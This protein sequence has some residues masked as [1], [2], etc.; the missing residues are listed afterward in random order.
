[1]ISPPSLAA[2]RSQT[3]PTIL[4][5]TTATEPGTQS[6]VDTPHLAS[7]HPST[8][9]PSS[10]ASSTSSTSSSYTHTISPVLVKSFSTPNPTDEQ[11]TRMRFEYMAFQRLPVELGRP[12]ALVSHEEEGLCLLYEDVRGEAID[13]VL[14]ENGR[15]AT[16]QPITDHTTAVEHIRSTSIHNTD[17]AT[18]VTLSPHSP[19]LPTVPSHHPKTLR[20]LSS[21]LRIARSLSNFLLR[22]HDNHVIYKCLRPSTILFNADTDRCLLLEYQSSSLLSRE[23]A[24]IEE[25]SEDGDPGLLSYISPEQ[26]GRMNRV[27]D[28]RTDIYSL[29][30]VMYEMLIGQPPFVSS[31]PL[32]IIHFH[33]AKACPDPVVLL[34][35]RR[36]AAGDDDKLSDRERKALHWLG[37]IILKCVAKQA[38]DRYQSA[39]G[40]LS[41]LDF[42]YKLL[43]SA[44]AEAAGLSVPATISPLVIS[45]SLTPD[46]R[47]S[48]SASSLSAVSVTSPLSQH[49]GVSPTSSPTMSSTASNQFHVGRTDVLS[50]FRISQRLYGREEQVKVLL[51]AFDRVS[52]DIEPATPSPSDSPP[53]PVRPELVLIAG[54]SGIGKT[55]VVDE[56]QRPI[57]K[58][59][60]LIARGKFD[61]YRRN[62]S[63]LLAAFQQLIMQLLTQDTTVWKHK[64]LTALGTDAQL[65][66]DVMPELERLIGPQSAVP[67]LPA[68]DTEKRFIRTFMNFVAVFCA[69]DHPLTLFI[70]D[71]QWSDT[72]SLHLIRSLFMMDGAF[73][74]IIGAYRDNE[75]PP[76]HPLIRMVEELRE[77]EMGDRI[78]CIML[79]PLQLHHITA[80]VS[81]TLRCST[82][83]AIELARLL[84]MRTQG[85]PF[86]ISSILQSL[87]TSKLIAF[88]YK[89]GRWTWDM[90][91]LRFAN[92]SSDVVDLLCGQIQRLEPR[93]QELMKL[94]ACIGN[95]FSLW[96]LA[97]V[98]EAAEEEVTYEM[99]QVS[100][101]G[102]IIPLHSQYEL[103]VLAENY[104]LSKEKGDT[105]PA[106]PSVS[107]SAS[108]TS[109][110]AP[111]HSTPAPVLSSSISST[112]PTP[113]ASSISPASPSQTTTALIPS[114]NSRTVLFRFAHDRIQQAASQLIP[115]NERQ[116][117]HL[118]IGRLLLSHCTVDTLDNSVVDIVNHFNQ[119][120]TIQ[121]LTSQ[122][123]MR[124]VI[125]L[126]LRAAHKARQS[127]AYA[128]AVEYLQAALQ[129]LNRLL[130]IGADGAVLEGDQRG[131][132]ECEYALSV[133]IHV[134]L[135]EALRLNVQLDEADALAV[136]AFAHTHTV[137]DQVAL[138]EVR[139][140]VS[141]LRGST[142]D[143]C[144]WGVKSLKLLGYELA[145]IEEVRDL[146]QHSEQVFAEFD[147]I[148]N[149]KEMTNPHH[150]AIFRVLQTTT[151]CS[152]LVSSSAYYLFSSVAYG[153]VRFSAEHGITSM[154]AFALSTFSH[155]L[156]A[157]QQPH[158][159]YK[160]GQMAMHMLDRQHAPNSV[161]AKVQT[162]Y[163]GCCVF[164]MEPLSVAWQGCEDTAEL[165]EQ[166]GDFEF[167]GF[168]RTYGQA[169][170]FADGQPLEKVRQ[171]QLNMMSMF[172]RKK[173]HGASTYLLMYRFLLA[174]LI[175]EIPAD[176]DTMLY[177]DRLVNLEL[178]LEEL[179]EARLTMFQLA[180]LSCQTMLNY[181]MRRF[182]RAVQAGDEGW[183]V[184]LH[185]GHSGAA[186]LISNVRL[187]VYYALS[188]L[189]ATP[190]VDLEAIR[191]PV[192]LNIPDTFD[193][194][195][196]FT[197]TQLKRA[198][199]L[200]AAAAAQPSPRQHDRVSP[201]SPNRSMVAKSGVY[202]NLTVQV[203][204]SN[205]SLSTS[206]VLARV[207]AI[208]RYVTLWAQHNPTNFLNKQLL[209][210]AERLRV[211]IFST[212]HVQ[213]YGPRY[214]LIPHALRLYE[215]SIALS[216]E[217]GFTQEEALANELCGRF[218]LAAN[219][220]RE[221]EGFLRSAYWCWAQYGCALK[222]QQMK[223]EFPH[224]FHT[225]SPASV[226]GSSGAP[227]APTG[228][229]TVRAVAGRSAGEMA[230][231]SML[232][233]D[234]MNES[235]PGAA[236]SMNMSHDSATAALSAT[237]TASLNA[238][239][240]FS[241]SLPMAAS[242]TSAGSGTSPP[243]SRP[244]GSHPP[245]TLATAANTAFAPAQP[246]PSSVSAASPSSWDH[247]DIAAVMKACMAFS[248]ET[249]LSKLTRSLLWLVIQ[250]AGASRGTLL[251]KTG[252]QW[253]VELVVSVE[254]KEGSQSVAGA[255]G[256]MKAIGSS[257]PLSM[258]N[259]VQSTHTAVLLSGNEVKQGA[260]QKDAYLSTHRPKACLAVPI[261]QQNKLTGLLYLQNDHTADSFTRTHL[262][263]LTVLTQQAALSIENARLYARLQQRT[264]ELQSNNSQLQ[265]EVVQRQAAQDAMRVAKEAAEKAAETKSAFL[266]NMSHEIRTPMNAVLGASRLLLDTDLTAEQ[267]SYLTM[268]TN[269]GKLLLTIINDV[270]DFSRIESN[271]LELEYRR[272]SLMECVEN[273]CHLCFD[274]AHKKQLD[275]AYTVDRHVPGY[276]Y[277]D[278]SRLQQILLNLLSNAC[279][280]TPPGGQI[281]VTVTCRL[282]DQGAPAVSTLAK[283][284]AAQ[285]LAQGHSPASTASSVAFSTPADSNRGNGGGISNSAVRSRIISATPQPQPSRRL[286]GTAQPSINTSSSASSTVGITGTP[287]LSQ[288]AHNSP[289]HT[290]NAPSTPHT[291]FTPPTRQY[292]ELEF[293]VRDTGLG[294][295]EETQSR[296]FKSFSQGDSSV[297]RRFGGTG[298]GLAISKRL[299][300]AM[301]GSMGCTSQVGEGS[302]FTFTIQTACASPASSRRTLISSAAAEPLQ[303]DP[304]PFMLSPLAS[305]VLP[306]VALAAPVVTLAPL[307]KLS[308][309]ELM[310]L[311]GKRIMLVSD[312]RASRETVV[313]L[314]SSYD[315]QVHAVPSL[316]A[317]MDFAQSV[318]SPKSLATHLSGDAPAV[319]FMPNGVILDYKG[320]ST[321]PQQMDIIDQ[322]MRAFVNTAYAVARA[323][324][325]YTQQYVAPTK[326]P[327]PSLYTDSPDDDAG[328]DAPASFTFTP[329]EPSTA[330]TS[331]PSNTS[332]PHSALSTISRLSITPAQRVLP[333]MAH[334]VV[335]MLTT[336]I[337]GDGDGSGNEL[338]MEF[339]K[340]LSTV[341]NVEDDESGKEDEDEADDTQSE[342]E[343]DEKEDDEQTEEGKKRAADQ[344]AEKA[345]STAVHP[346]DPALFTH[347]MVLAKLSNLEQHAKRKDERQLRHA[348][349]KDSKAR[350]D[351]SR[352]RMLTASQKSKHSLSKSKVIRVSGQPLPSPT[353]SSSDAPIYYASSPS[354]SA[355][356]GSLPIVSA[357]PS[358]DLL[359]SE[360]PPHM[361]ELHPVDRTHY[362]LLELTKPYHQSDL[363]QTLAEHLPDDSGSTGQIRSERWESRFSSANSEASH[364]L[365]P[366]VMDE[367]DINSAGS[368]AGSEGR[369]RRERSDPMRS[370][371]PP[372][373]VPRSSIESAPSVGAE[374]SQQ[375]PVPPL[376]RKSSGASS[377]AQPQQ[378]PD[379]STLPAPSTTTL[380]IS[381]SPSPPS[382]ESGRHSLAVALIAL[383]RCH[384]CRLLTLAHP[385]PT[386][387]ASHP[388]HSSQHHQSKPHLRSSLLTSNPAAHQLVTHHRLHPLLHHLLLPLRPPL[389]LSPVPTTAEHPTHR[390]RLPAVAAAG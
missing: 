345:L 185:Q 81:D 82:D 377:R 142:Q 314:L 358:P 146:A 149:G 166:Q 346:G 337:V 134:Q 263:I 225:D 175:G 248:V 343:V 35:A 228:A 189:A 124:E 341:L 206:H 274:M 32:E 173:M 167:S 212:T 207:T 87:Y 90:E 73:L 256:D 217:S 250:T 132:W 229:T 251:L 12:L 22:L 307:H 242:L 367:V 328:R 183:Q 161:R 329:I 65:L 385:Y 313:K 354:S 69:A 387:V 114:L 168:C 237:Q 355:S 190:C 5:S 223:A 306:P 277:G 138:L 301:H 335:I 131:V 339:V 383:V 238:S 311:A 321:T 287:R 202:R 209:L 137:L 150:L 155:V 123:E 98:A 33:L 213:R 361:L 109:T 258:F 10:A 72:T 140:D 30:T 66:I 144:D 271:N 119:P 104:R 50:R 340:P 272:F 289:L 113:A 254:D 369:M 236:L 318:A 44:D 126:E 157:E 316:Q 305:P 25:W 15:K 265:S 111:L 99:W 259:L 232:Q 108:T 216:R 9:N 54:Y 16:E 115:A 327:A 280:F 2:V 364:D 6:P 326:A 205:G 295:S 324:S 95:T 156:W 84:Q 52:G 159:C 233:H 338:I 261:L 169:L 112:A 163:Y 78:H 4:A 342:E 243:S 158:L 227:A 37:A 249:D 317:A 187:L 375:Q 59:R 14:Y 273:A 349:R 204:D 181:Y 85:N 197:A 310:R 362:S 62:Q 77:E 42:C 83:A 203:G 230:I 303:R 370:S 174:K 186:A 47:P 68:L 31:D 260:F 148:V 121:L 234:S 93:Q 182:N 334:P 164:W 330:S 18:T 282:L 88:D 3:Q 46:A 319:P 49:N 199:E 374:G 352:K 110:T 276:I 184:F 135:A 269:S 247:V 384:R 253:A 322:L 201:I 241:Y 89:A 106:L 152:V 382:S 388:T 41:D 333:V 38:E 294:M 172:Q 267:S 320:C 117:V 151:S 366:C 177:G 75:T 100:N 60:G 292:V 24:I 39:A 293:S 143:A 153:M 162:T 262:Q 128:P 61:L 8:S 323:Q 45:R 298:L 196:G 300:L 192:G 219:S 356:S 120:G 360:S 53:R 102:L 48:S 103:F 299:A 74:L 264:Q 133:A 7:H 231:D 344:A 285:A 67:P 194:I 101:N 244:V 281:V 240:S 122:R 154:S 70:D 170:M 220:K 208:Q 390:R 1:M 193:A 379:A 278:S 378:S 348:I 357:M 376:W 28:S 222:Q 29:G 86:F 71:L 351:S 51:D 40:L 275:L 178:Q 380:S 107:S 214:D 21:I 365:S 257:M 91:Q 386:L 165:C 288:S 26:T 211:Y 381:P 80:L 252:D 17:A 246:T 97:V 235:G 309:Y 20:P 308:E 368:S 76:L 350:K 296:L 188:M 125:Q 347:Q 331:S 224:I 130:P 92:I 139:Q 198:E 23:R 116:H 171:K 304:G 191:E 176:A 64:L 58:K 55:S 336:R 63:A 291:T 179:K 283:A 43:M 221:G 118:K 315:M 136:S 129:L 145:S 389:H 353:S 195:L 141:K 160:A 94:A 371:P 332:S 245:P 180:N 286:G 302:T 325:S 96:T 226:A 373:A 210:D 312:L 27:L 279:K 363:L 11:V 127:N 268:I 34:E 218:C 290:P 372:P 105:Q 79:Q 56:V 239:P 57:V 255:P 147:R 266:S 297:V 200:D 13:S 19:T 284:A 36:R 215:K 270:L 359:P